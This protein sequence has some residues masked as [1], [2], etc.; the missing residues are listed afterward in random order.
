MAGDGKTQ[1]GNTTTKDRRPQS[2]SY[3]DSL[4]A[5]ADCFEKARRN[6]PCDDKKTSP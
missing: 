5:R 1:Q 3:A 6:L 2:L 4:R